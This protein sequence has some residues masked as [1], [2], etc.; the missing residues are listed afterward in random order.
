MRESQEDGISKKIVQGTAGQWDQAQFAER[1]VI[2]KMSSEAF[3][4]TNNTRM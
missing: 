4:N 3:A 1:R 2:G